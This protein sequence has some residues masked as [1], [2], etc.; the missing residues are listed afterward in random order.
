MTTN[1]ELVRTDLLHR[2]KNTPSAAYTGP[3]AILD[4]YDT[5]L[6]LSCYLR[7]VIEEMTTRES[8]S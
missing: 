5:A 3:A 8:P 4:A 7:Q 2:E 1:E 6:D